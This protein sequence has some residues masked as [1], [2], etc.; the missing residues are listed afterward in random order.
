MKT[1]IKYTI[2]ISANYPYIDPSQSISD[3]LN[4]ALNQ[5][6]SDRIWIPELST[7]NEDKHLNELRPITNQGSGSVSITIER[8]GDIVGRHRFDELAGDF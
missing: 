4:I 3:Q 7:M 8:D 5:M 1:N 2:E 6:V